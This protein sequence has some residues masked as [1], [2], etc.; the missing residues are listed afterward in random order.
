MP[1]LEGSC[2]VRGETSATR[3]DVFSEFFEFHMRIVIS[4]MFH[5]H[6][7]AQPDVCDSPNQAANYV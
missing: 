1:S 7:A 5:V 3:A 2:G 4:V 6:S